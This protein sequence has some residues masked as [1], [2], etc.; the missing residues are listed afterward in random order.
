MIKDT[1][2]N[3]SSELEHKRLIIFGCGTYFKRF[4]DTYASLLDKIEIILDN[5]SVNDFFTIETLNKKIP[6]VKPEKIRDWCMDNYVVLFCCRD[7]SRRDA[8][9]TQL[10]SY[11]TENGY[12]KFFT[13]IYEGYDIYGKQNMKNFIVE[14]IELL[15][16]M[17][18]H[19]GLK[20]YDR[21]LQVCN[22][23]SL[24]EVKNEIYTRNKVIVSEIVV[25]LT[26]R[27]T[28]RCK[29]CM[30]FMWAFDKDVIDV[31]LEQ[32]CQALSRII[33]A[34][35]CIVSVSVIG[36]EPFLADS[37]MGVLQFLEKQ[38]KVL[39]TYITTNGTV[40]IKDEWIPLLKRDNLLLRISNYEH[41]VK[42]DSLVESCI[43]NGIHFCHDSIGD[44][45]DFGNMEKRNRNED[46]LRMQYEGCMFSRRCKT[47]WGDQLFACQVSGSLEKLGKVDGISL[48]ISECSDLR[49]ELLEFLLTPNYEACDYCEADFSDLK[50]LSTAEQ[51]ER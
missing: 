20:V 16:D 34:V 27:C 29:G 39:V 15:L 25:I 6:I 24:S 35:D 19:N 48:N 9:K 43:T 49:N 32:T 3:L 13:P 42:Q 21:L 12:T 40:P 45:I 30:N 44:W 11:F 50:F 41:I 51:L 46:Q 47:M 1:Y 36:G 26:T 4:C 8:M 23:N 7:D 37:F 17:Y 33:E 2:K 31:P 38:E 28:M 14:H 5:Y 18:E 22:C 10:D